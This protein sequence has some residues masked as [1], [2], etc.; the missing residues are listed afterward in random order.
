MSFVMPWKHAAC[1]AS[2]SVIAHPSG[3]ILTPSSEDVIWPHA[4]AESLI[5]PQAGSYELLESLERSCSTHNRYS[6]NKC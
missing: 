2:E 3:L 4:S 5:L 6:V 1:L